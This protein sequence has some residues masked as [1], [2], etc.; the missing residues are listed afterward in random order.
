MTPQSAVTQIVALKNNVAFIDMA[1]TLLST[2][3]AAT[4][5]IDPEKQ[6]KVKTSDTSERRLIYPGPNSSPYEPVFRCN[7]LGI[8]VPASI[9]NGANAARAASTLP[10]A[11][12]QRGLSGRPC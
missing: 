11:I 12:S 9:P 5:P 8:A 1:P 10:R 7:T 6:F 3:G 2:S 4:V